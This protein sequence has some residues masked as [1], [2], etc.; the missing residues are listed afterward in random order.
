MYDLVVKNGLAALPTGLRRMDIAIRDGK[1]AAMGPDMDIEAKTIVG[2]EGKYVL[3]GVVDAH[4][5]FNDP[6]YPDRE[7]MLSGTSAAAAGGAT[8]I[9]D[10][11]LSGN[12]TVTSAGTLALKKDAAKNKA[13]VDYALWAGLVDDNTSQMEDIQ[14]AGAIAFKAFTCFAGDD[15]PYATSATLYRGMLNA[16][17]TDSI[18]GVHC[19]DQN[20]VA[21]FEKEARMRGDYTIRAFLD[22]HAP[23]TEIA[24]TGMVL[25]LAKET[26]ARVHIC[27]AS[28]PEIVNMVKEARNKGARVTVETCPHYLLF[29]E[30]DQEQQRGFLKCTPPVRTEMDSAQLWDMLF[31]GSIDMISS[32]HSPSTIAQK[33]PESGNFF[34]A[35]GGTHGVQTMLSV[36]Y[37]EGVLKRGIPMEH[38]VRLLSTNPAMVFGLYPQKGVIRPESDADF[39]IFDPGEEWT[40]SADTLIHKNKHSPY[41]D[42]KLT[43]RVK[44]TYVRGKQV[45]ADGKIIAEPGS[46][47]LITRG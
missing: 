42:M 18:I 37:T 46:G 2:A 7:D 47:K 31:D 34:E 40:V 13:V 15:F 41:M 28:L 27:H 10:M 22:A 43:G 19:E 35:W 20:L 39:V 6:G 17:Q 23:I 38:L 45:Y 25:E 11:P 12:P 4:V 3:P 33:T 8:T 9:F 36:M 1:F 21:S 14:E 30:E 26:G 29:T 32:D 5:H 16:F 24:A 44:H